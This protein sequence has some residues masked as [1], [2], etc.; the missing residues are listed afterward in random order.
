MIKE[1][2]ENSFTEHPKVDLFADPKQDLITEDCKWDFITED[3][4]DNLFTGSP[5]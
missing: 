5:K 2:K 3:P 1:L 4:K